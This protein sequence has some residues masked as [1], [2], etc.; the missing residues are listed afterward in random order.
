MMTCETRV[1]G[2]IY[3]ANEAGRGVFSPRVDGTYIQHVGTCDTPRF[4]SGRQLGAWVRRHLEV[5][6]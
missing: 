5:R 2:R 6:P 1:F 4:R 3:C